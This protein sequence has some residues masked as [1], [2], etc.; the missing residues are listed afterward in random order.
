MRLIKKD[1]SLVIKIFKRT[2]K[3][4]KVIVLP[5]GYNIIYTAFML[6]IMLPVM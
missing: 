4:K 3:S 6:L 5:L 1:Y 2:H